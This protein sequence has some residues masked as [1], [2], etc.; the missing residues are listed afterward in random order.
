MKWCWAGKQN[1]ITW[2]SRG[3]CVIGGGGILPVTSQWLKKM[4]LKLSFSSRKPSQC[5]FK[6]KETQR[7]MFAVPLQILSVLFVKPTTLTLTHD[8][9]ERVTSRRLGAPLCRT[10]RALIAIGWKLLFSF[11]IKNLFIISERKK[12]PVPHLKMVIT[13]M[14]LQ[15]SAWLAE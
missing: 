13:A 15:P 7:T 6:R 3:R 11:P 12:R 1:Y 9:V 4:I 2:A 5:C 14:H 10:E 8:R